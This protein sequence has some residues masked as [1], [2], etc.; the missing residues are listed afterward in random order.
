MFIEIEP[1]TLLITDTFNEDGAG[2]IALTEDQARQIATSKYGH[3]QFMYVDGSL[4]EN[5]DVIAE[6]TLARKRANAS[7][8]PLEFWKAVDNLGITSQVE[9]I[10]TDPNTP[11]LTF[12]ELNEASEF[13]RNWPTL[14]QLATQ[15]G[16]TEQQ[17]DQEFGI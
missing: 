7:L 6:I 3:A 15:L 8:T 9:A 1:N 14:I 17:L 16:I 2:R 13:K 10:R 11:R 4:V 12:L 5:P